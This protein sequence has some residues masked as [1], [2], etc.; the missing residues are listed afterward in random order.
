MPVYLFSLSLILLLSFSFSRSPLLSTPLNRRNKHPKAVA[1]KKNSRGNS[2][3]P[4]LSS[5]LLLFLSLYASISFLSFFFTFSLFFHPPP[6]PTLALYP[7]YASLSFLSL[8]FF[9]SLSLFSIPPTPTLALYPPYA[10]LSFSLPP[11][12][13]LFF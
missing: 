9:S 4:S 13:S 7:P 10:S 5:P 6:T 12:S 1:N 8:S 11:S 3:S 2:C